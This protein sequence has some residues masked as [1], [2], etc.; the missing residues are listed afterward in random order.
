M[1]T[2][3]LGL[4]TGRDERDGEVWGVWGAEEPAKTTD[5]YAI[6]N[7]QCPIPINHV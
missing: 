2:G 1:G 5:K 7:P 3:D 6:P 4:G